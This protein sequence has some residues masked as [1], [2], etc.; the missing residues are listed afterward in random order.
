M[1]HILKVQLRNVEISLRTEQQ[2]QLASNV[3]PFWLQRAF[4]VCQICSVVVLHVIVDV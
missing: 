1:L 4:D 2:A 3:D